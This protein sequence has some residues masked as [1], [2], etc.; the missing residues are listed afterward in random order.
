MKRWRASAVV[1][2]C[3]AFLIEAPAWAPSLPAGGWRARWSWL[4]A[5]PQRAVSL[6]AGFSAWLI[7]A[8]LLVVAG[9]AVAAASARRSGRSLHRAVELLTPRFAR[10]LV[11]VLLGAA[12]AVASAGPAVASTAPATRVG[13][14]AL[15]SLAPVPAPVVAPPELPPVLALDR[16]GASPSHTT[17]PVPAPPHPPA[18]MPQPAAPQTYRV[19]PGD[20]LWGLAAKRLPASSSPAAITR[21]WQRWYAANRR[22][23]GPDPG[24]LLIGELLDIPQETL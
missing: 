14:G 3:G 1:L 18:A 10:G 19:R 5:D 7:A 22:E 4:V 13:A 20:T 2:A 11:R 6:L 12:V 15:P 21:A 9:L 17:S 8:W 24:L 16:P 23:I